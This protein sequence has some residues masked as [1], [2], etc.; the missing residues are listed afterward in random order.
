MG[1]KKSGFH[2]SI[3]YFFAYL[4]YAIIGLTVSNLSFALSGVFVVLF[5]LMD[6]RM[7]FF[8]SILIG[9]IDVDLIG[10]MA[11]NNVSLDTL[12]YGELVMSVGLTVDYIIHIAHAITDAQPND[13]NNFRERLTIAFHDMGVGVAKG[14]LTTFI[15]IMV[16]IF[17]QSQA[18][19]IFFLMFCG[20]IFIS[21]LHGFL[22]IPAIM[23]EFPV[24]YLSQDALND[25]NT[26]ENN[27]GRTSPRS[28]ADHFNKAECDMTVIN[29]ANEPKLDATK[30]PR[31]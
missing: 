10:W 9:M 18:F 4:A 8:I 29:D 23:A 19:R 27:N 17:S 1:D 7:A 5:L 16:L 20:I 12:A 3:G 2:F 25:A 21:V 13:P 22:L 14:A 15:G 6:I 24:L 11:L 28:I 31:L 30:S 26:E